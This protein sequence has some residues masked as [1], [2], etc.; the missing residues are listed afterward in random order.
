M[1]GTWWG[2]MGRRRCFRRRFWRLGSGP[3]DRVRGTGQFVA[4]LMRIARNFCLKR[5][6]SGQMRRRD[7]SEVQLEEVAREGGE[8]G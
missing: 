6:S 4:W 1:R 3:A 2:R 7:Q 5:L 8:A